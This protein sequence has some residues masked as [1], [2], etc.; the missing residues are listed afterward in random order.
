LSLRGQGRCEIDAVGGKIE[1][2]RALRG[3]SYEV[4][5]TDLQSKMGE[6]LILVKEMHALRPALRTIVLAPAATPQEIIEAL[7][8]RVY[9]VYTP[10]FSSTEVAGM[11]VNALEADSWRNGIELTSGLPYWLTLRVTSH[12]VTAERLTQF[13]KE[14]RSDLPDEQRDDLMVAFREVLVNA[15]EH[16]AGFDP[17]KTIEVS[18]ARTRRAIVYHFRDPGPGFDLDD[19]PH[20]ALGNP[21]DQPLAHLERRNERGLRPGGFGLLI[22]KQL[23]D[24]MV[25]NETGNEVLLIKYTE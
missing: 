18:A 8:E 23:V 2:L 16:G 9:A 1:A 6:D 25:Y 21:P 12:L 24:E 15:M 5:I 7:R 17:E 22:A 20:S 14:Y 3:R 19:L 10:T 11:V 13:M 4:A